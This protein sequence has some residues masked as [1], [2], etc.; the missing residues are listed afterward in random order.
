MLNSDVFILTSR[1]E[2]HPMGL[3]EALAYGLPAVVSSGSNM[4]D[5]IENADAG[6]TCD[7]SVESLRQALLTMIGEKDKFQIK[8]I[9]AATLAKGYDWTVLAAKL[10][11]I[12]C[13]LQIV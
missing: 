9:N 7:T 13:D 1:F 4:K 5:E 6:W 11:K 10:H 12:L 8:S 3:I 2:G